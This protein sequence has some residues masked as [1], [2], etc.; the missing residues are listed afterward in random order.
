MMHV[1]AGRVSFYPPSIR[2]RVLKS[3]SLLSAERATL[4]DVDSS[5]VRIITQSVIVVGDLHVSG[6]TIF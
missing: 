5:C 3:A 6:G 2:T 1:F 4:L